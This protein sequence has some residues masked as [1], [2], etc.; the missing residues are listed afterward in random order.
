MKRHF[1]MTSMCKYILATVA[2]VILLLMPANR[3]LAMRC[4]QSKVLGTIAPAGVDQPSDIAVGPSGRIYLVDGVNNRIVVTDAD[5]KLQF[6]F[7]RSGGKAGELKHPLGID[8]SKKGRVFI[9]DTG[10]HRV[11]VFD[12]R[13]KFLYMFPATTTAWIPNLPC[14]RALIRKILRPTRWAMSAMV[15]KMNVRS[16]SS[17]GSTTR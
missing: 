15:L 5:G 16:H 17:P 3:L 6:T 4:L 12:P 1:E 14:I 10:N 11:Q 9:A 8:I 13:G 7:G 2:A